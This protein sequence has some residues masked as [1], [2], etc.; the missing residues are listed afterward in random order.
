ML[1]LFD[2]NLLIIQG[3]EY[4]THKNINIEVTKASK[5]AIAAIERNNGSVT[6]IYHTR[7]GLRQ[8]LK[9]D[10]M[11][12]E[13]YFEP[14]ILEKDIEY[15]VN[16]ANRG[17]LADK[18]RFDKIYRP[19]GYTYSAEEYD[20]IA[21]PEKVSAV[22]VRYQVE[23]MSQLLKEMNERRAWRQMW[24]EKEQES[25][26]Q[27]KSKRKLAWKNQQWFP[28]QDEKWK[29]VV[30]NEDKS[31]KFNSFQENPPVKEKESVKAS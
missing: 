27:A 2:F 25:L 31:I 24:Y 6:C 13:H 5:S 29:W 28:D 11:A 16:P 20:K 9:N 14:P 30:L 1:T 3:S 10:K 18:E 19:R 23:N 22:K 21:S 7:S 4:F 26:S 17:Y 15:Y 12:V 8:H